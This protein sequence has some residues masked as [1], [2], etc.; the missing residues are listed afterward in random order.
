MSGIEKFSILI[1]Y[2]FI[3]NST[4]IKINTFLHHNDYRPHK[5]ELYNQEFGENIN[6]SL[7]VQSLH[8]FEEVKILISGI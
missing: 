4:N 2:N 5:A 8:H 1:Y 7:I 3:A 6:L